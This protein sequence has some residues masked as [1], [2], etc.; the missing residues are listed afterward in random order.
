MLVYNYTSHI[1]I[2]ADIATTMLVYNYTSHTKIVAGIA[3]TIITLVT[4]RL[5]QVLLQL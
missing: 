1:K 4:S 3:T 2:V 5:R